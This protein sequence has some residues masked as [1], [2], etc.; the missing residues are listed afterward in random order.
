MKKLIFF[1]SLL[2]F[3]FRVNAMEYYSNYGEFSDYQKDVV[4]KDDLT[5]V[6]KTKMYQLY[7]ENI[8]Y[9]YLENSLFKET[10]NTKVEKTNWV[11]DISLLEKDKEV[12]KCYEYSYNP[13][14]EYNYIVFT[15]ASDETFKISKLEFYDNKTNKVYY[16]HENVILNPNDVFHLDLDK[17][18]SLDDTNLR[19]NIVGYN[20]SRHIKT[21]IYLAIDYDIF[22]YGNYLTTLEGYDNVDYK[23]D[24]FRK[25]KNIFDTTKTIN[26]CFN[27]LR[28]N[29]SEYNTKYRNIINLK[30]H[31]IINKEYIDEYAK[32]DTDIYK[33]D[34][35]KYI[36]LYRYK[37][38]DKVIISDDIVINSNDKNLK[39]F[40]LYSSINI[41]DIKII[42]NIDYT[43]NG[44]YE[45]KYILPF[46]EV[47]KEV[48]VDI[49]DN[50]EELENIKDLKEEKLEVINTNNDLNNS[51]NNDLN[52]KEETIKEIAEELMNS[53]YII[54]KKNL[55]IKEV[56][57]EEEK[58]NNEIKEEL[59]A[60]KVEK[61]KLEEQKI[62]LKDEKE[63]K[64][65]SMIYMYILLLL[66]IVLYAIKRRLL[67]KNS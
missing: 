60:C 9:E 54:D 1:L 39:D 57:L 67:K 7:K 56:I 59:N 31:E 11:D 22:D 5:L 27:K 62:E 52:D 51:I 28:T 8:S 26:D 41:D 35:S 63:I 21:K 24:D 65:Q 14:K 58:N 18:Y 50:E 2:L 6:E 55:E 3:S 15:N 29:I 10:G 48:L 38:R 34:S 40:I 4:V 33:I 44:T 43:K 30:E 16:T 13:I 17:K 49:K 19:I 23:I 66:I 46:K 37:K 36:Y 61:K 32:K 25:Y 45:V 53:S 47:I 12:E 64:E 42:D 20:S